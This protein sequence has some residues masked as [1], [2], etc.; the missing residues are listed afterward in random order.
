MATEAPAAAEQH[1]GLPIFQEVLQALIHQRPLDETLAL[2][3]RRV[4]EL[5]GFD[6][7]GIFLPDARWEHVHLAASYAFP[8]RYVSRLNDIFLAPLGDSALAGSPTTAAIR[9]RHTAV[10][11][12]AL[13]DESFRPWRPLAAEF[14]YRS[15][16]SV[17]LVVQGEVLGILNGY[18][19][20]PRELTPA[21][22]QTV[23]T[24][25]SQAALALRMTMLVDAQQE[26]NAQLREANEQ[27]DRQREM[28][29]RSH[30][31][32]MRLTS[33]VIAGAGFHPVAQ[34]LAGLIGRAVLVTDAAGN[35]ICTSDPLPDPGLDAA[36]GHALVGRIRIG[37]ELLGR[38]VVE[39]GPPESRELDVRAVEHA[40]TVL[41]LE[42]VKERVARATEERLRSDFLADLLDGRREEDDERIGERARHHGLSLAAGHRVVV[43]A[44][45]DRAHGDLSESASRARRGRLLGAVATL[46]GELLPGSL[47][48]RIDDAVAVAALVARDGGADDVA[49]L[50]AAVEQARERLSG[51]EPGV[52]LT[53]G[54]GPPTSGAAGFPASYAGAMR[55][56]EV[57]RRL[58][59]AGDTMAADELG[60]LGLFVDS[61]RPD[62]LR[63]LARQILGPA[64]DHDARTGGALLR[65][66]ETYLSCNCD[67][68]ACAAQLYVHVNTVRYR[69]RQVQEL[70]GVDLRDPQDLLRVTV[71]RLIVRLLEPP[72]TCGA[73]Q[74]G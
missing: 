29:E 66:L 48:G 11:V 23:E 16:V 22:L 41:A 34:T 59:R 43:V 26:T 65:T 9:M 58:G 62:E 21:Q 56:I 38:V 28:L 8:P 57:L 55:S 17:P 49:R 15:L 14:G 46:I 44:A 67:A 52:A 13:S 30:D 70:C 64:L 7:C 54:I 69:L 61:A 4:S 51:R 74:P 45:D 32:H 39:E 72:G 63:A 27:L 5:A 37:A 3:S 47:T 12:D 71:A 20:E 6:F 33:A 1:A 40:A 36:S 35:A 50:R 73:G 19:H 25:A 18:A 60:L 2:I 31:I 53:A 10:M 68:A 42:I 24:L